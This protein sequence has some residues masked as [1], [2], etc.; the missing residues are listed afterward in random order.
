[1]APRTKAFPFKGPSTLE[2]FKYIPEKAE[3]LYCYVAIFFEVKCE[4]CGQVAD[5]SN[6]MFRRPPCSKS[7]SQFAHVLMQTLQLQGKIVLVCDSDETRHVCDP[8]GVIN[9][10]ITNQMTSTRMFQVGFNIHGVDIA[11]CG[12]FTVK[13]Y[14]LT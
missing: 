10:S 12:I 6:V 14:I 3:L 7:R 1:M 8:S 9:I 13:V 4:V 11:L 5:F 2:K